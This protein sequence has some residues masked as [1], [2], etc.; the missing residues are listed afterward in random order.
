VNTP[1]EPA[2]REP[3]KALHLWQITAVREAFWL[4]IIVLLIWGAYVLRAL[5][6]PLLI[7]LALA[8]VADPAIRGLQR[9]AHVPR[10]ITAFVALLALIAAV[11][12]FAIWLLPKLIVQLTQLS[13]QLPVY[14]EALQR[15]YERWEGALTSAPINADSAVGTIQADSVIQGAYR[16]VGPLFGILGS[17]VGTAG[18]LVASAVLIPILFVYFATYYDRLASLKR[19]IPASRRERILELLKG[20]DAAFSGYVRGQLVVALFTTVGFCVGFYLVDV[21]YWFV[22][23]LIGGVLSLV[24]YGQMSGWLL[25]MTLKYAEV[26]TGSNAFSW[27]GILIAPS[28]VYA[29][30]QSMETWVITPLVQGEATNLHPVVVLVAL[31]IGGALAGIVGLILAVPVTASAKMLIRELAVPRLKHWADTH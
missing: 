19:F 6:A 8:Y 14:W 28:L 4:A 27:F 23:A 20:V 16:S 18:F 21:P 17:A 12:A 7:A 31:I 15:Q 1:T 2:K 3:T 29:V 24:P 5:L 25:A 10:V 30:T 26:Q 13:E 22:V 9:R 11:S